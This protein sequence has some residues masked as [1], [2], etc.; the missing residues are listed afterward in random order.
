M[1][2]NWFSFIMAIISAVVMIIIASVTVD[3]V[4]SV[5]NSTPELKEMFKNVYMGFTY[6]AAVVNVLFGVWSLFKKGGCTA[7]TV[8]GILLLFLGGFVI[9]LVS[10]ILNLIAGS[11]GKSRF[12]K[13]QAEKEAAE[14]YGAAQNN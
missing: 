12:I 8:W 3:F 6:F 9:F 10:A 13:Y 1:K 7:L 4:V 2:K 14:K 5:V 11:K